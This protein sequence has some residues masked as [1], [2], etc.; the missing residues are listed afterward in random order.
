MPERWSTTSWQAVRW[1]QIMRVEN[2]L[3]PLVTRSLRLSLPLMGIP[4]LFGEPLERRR[5]RR[6]YTNPRYLGSARA[7]RIANDTNFAFCPAQP[8]GSSDSSGAEWRRIRQLW[9]KRSHQGTSGSRSLGLV[10]DL[11]A[12]GRTDSTAPSSTVM[13]SVV[14]SGRKSC[15]IC[16]PRALGASAASS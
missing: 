11:V 14:W 7:A 16:F 3:D 10:I 8:A 12:D 1:V 2:I 4:P 5:N 13:S 6:P 15:R 9:A